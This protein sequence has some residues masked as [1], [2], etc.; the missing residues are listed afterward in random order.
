MVS[1]YRPSP[2]SILRNVPSGP[3][4]YPN[5]V[6]GKAR[7]TSGAGITGFGS[8]FEQPSRNAAARGM[9]IAYFNLGFGRSGPVVTDA[10]SA[11]RQVR[12]RIQ[13]VE[14]ID[15]NRRDRLRLGK[16]HVDCH[17]APSS[18]VEH[19]SAPVRRSAGPRTE[20]QTQRVGADIGRG[21]AG[22]PDTFAFIV[23]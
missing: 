16:S 5:H 13:A 12:E 9:E 14:V 23:I 1:W 7:R 20:I 11:P 3:C 17:S 8:C 10:A 6:S 21:L 22:D 19:S 2:P 15:R 4:H 18:S